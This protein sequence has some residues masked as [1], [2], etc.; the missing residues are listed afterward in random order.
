MPEQTL[1]VV[2]ERI[3]NLKEHLTGKLISIEKQV[4]KT[5]GNVINHSKRIRALENWRW[6]L[7]GGGSVILFGFSLVIKFL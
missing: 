1:A 5:N 7:L 4:T 6:L 2:I 3:D